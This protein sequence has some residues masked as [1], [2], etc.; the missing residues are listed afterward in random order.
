[1]ML[2]LPWFTAVGQSQIFLVLFHLSYLRQQ[3][4]TERNQKIS[5]DYLPF[6]EFNA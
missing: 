2:W 4:E 3:L 6:N 5:Y 1:M